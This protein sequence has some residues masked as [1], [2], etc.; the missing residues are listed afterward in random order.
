MNQQTIRNW[1]DEGRLPT[2]A[3]GGVSVSDAP[4]SN[5]CLSR[6]TAAEVDAD[7]RGEEHAASRLDLADG[8]VGRR[9]DPLLPGEVAQSPD[10]R[11]GRVARDLG[12]RSAEVVGPVGI[13]VVR[14][15]VQASL[16]REAISAFN[17]VLTASQTAEQNVAKART[18][19]AQLLQTATQAADHTVQVARAQASERANS[20]LR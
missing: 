4:T 10:V 20:E 15:D 11:V 13:D 12:H 7:T 19:A 6:A 2:S 16:P 3:S 9:A 5:G 1:M 14:V 8:A 17:A 18:E